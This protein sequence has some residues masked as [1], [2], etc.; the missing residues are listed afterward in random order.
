[1]TCST[2]NEELKISN[3]GR[4]PGNCVLKGIAGTAVQYRLKN[5]EKSIP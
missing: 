3:L 2:S 4:Q 5:V 1:M